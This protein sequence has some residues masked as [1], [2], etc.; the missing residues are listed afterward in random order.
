MPLVVVPGA[1][2]QTATTAMTPGPAHMG[3]LTAGLARLVEM[4]ST[5]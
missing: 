4:V 1:M 5:E 3:H 2:W